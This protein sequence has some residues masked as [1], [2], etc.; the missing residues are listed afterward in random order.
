MLRPSSPRNA[1]R[2]LAALA[3]MSPGPVLE[4]GLALEGI[5]P[6]A[7]AGVLACHEH[8]VTGRAIQLALGRAPTEWATVCFFVPAAVP[9][10]LAH[11]DL[12]RPPPWT[13]RVAEG[14]L[15][16]HPWTLC[17]TDALADSVRDA[18][19][20]GREVYF[21]RS[22]RYMARREALLNTAA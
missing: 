21:P 11:L 12:A 7:A 22:R 17:A 9:P 10:R 16:T 6:A 5:A 3:E 2:R 20:A 13:L 14:P 4:A 19:D 18:I 15:A 8:A 1:A